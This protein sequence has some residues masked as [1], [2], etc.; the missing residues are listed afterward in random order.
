MQCFLAYANAHDARNT[1]NTIKHAGGSLET[2][3]EK[4]GQEPKRRQVPLGFPHTS[5]PEEEPQHYTDQSDAHTCNLIPSMYRGCVALFRGRG[6]FG[7]AC[8]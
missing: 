8:P 5:K 6:G 1:E 3:S 2:C 7:T 4:C